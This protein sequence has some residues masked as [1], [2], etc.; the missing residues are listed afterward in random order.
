MIYSC[1]S[2]ISSTYIYTY[3]HIH[4]NTP[5]IYINSKNIDVNIFLFFKIINSNIIGKERRGNGS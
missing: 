4:I 3:T 2:P 1:A 5:F